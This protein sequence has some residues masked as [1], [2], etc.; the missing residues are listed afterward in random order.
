MIFHPFRWSLLPALLLVGVGTAYSQEQPIWLG[1]DASDVARKVVHCR[2]R[3]SVQPGALT[4]YYPKWLPGDHSPSGPILNVVNLHMEAGE[5]PTAQHLGK[6]QAVLWQRDPVEMYTLHCDVPPNVSILELEFDS[7]VPASKDKL[8]SAKLAAIL[9]NTCLFYPAGKPSDQITIQAGLKLPPNW[10]FGTALPVE[11]AEGDKVAFAPVSLTTL[12]DSPVAAGAYQRTVVLNGAEDGPIHQLDI[13][14]D[15][16]AALELP[17]ETINHYKELVTQ[18]KALFGATHYRDYHFLVCLSDNIGHNGL[19]HHE[20]SMNTLA[21]RAFIDPALREAAGELLPHEFVHSWNGKYRRPVGLA[22][23]DYQVPMQDGLL[24]VYEGLT[25]YLGSFVLAARSGL[26]NADWSHEM[27]ASAAASLD[28]KAGRTWR[29]LQD[30]ADAASIL[31]DAPGDWANLRRGVD[32]YPEGILLWLEADTIIRQVSKGEKTLDDFCRAFHGGESGPPKVVPYTFEDVVKGLNDVAAY[33]WA[34]FLTERLKST[35]PRAPL[36]GIENAGWK[37]VYTDQPNRVDAQREEEDKKVDLRYSLGLALNE[38]GTV[39]DVTGG[40]PAL[41]A[42]L[43]PGMK[44]VAVNNRV[45]TPKL[46]KEATAAT[47]KPGAPPI[48]LLMQNE[49]FFQTYRLNYKGGEQYPHLVRDADKPD[50]MEKI[51]QAGPKANF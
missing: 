13:V 26:D 8:S 37:V 18:A 14:A 39:A 44:L 10:K 21:E 43:A 36:G 25:E 5:Q 2:E 9:W 47:A 4:L 22:T 40:G 17:E 6:G 28:H 50:V 34:N 7:L 15:S 31:Y 35:S 33:D 51:L 11:K 49:D 23:P 24:W 45:W 29:N 27:L 38:D 42:G 1:V 32:F 3:I 30:T 20:S 16:A 46:L 12:V 41:A 48:S 19:E